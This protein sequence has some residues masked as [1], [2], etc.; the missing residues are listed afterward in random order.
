MYNFCLF[1]F[2]FFVLLYCI[3]IP[4]ILIPSYIHHEHEHAV[5]GI[6]EGDGDHADAEVVGVVV[7]HYGFGGMGL[8][9]DAIGNEKGQQYDDKCKVKGGKVWHPAV[10]HNGHKQCE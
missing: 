6:F 7:A 1:S 8:G 2:Y 9:E 10:E 4:P 3:R 5:E